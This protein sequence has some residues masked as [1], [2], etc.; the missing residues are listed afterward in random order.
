[1]AIHRF[2]GFTQKCCLS[3][4]NHF[5][6]NIFV[7]LFDIKRLNILYVLEAARDICVYVWTG[8]LCS[9]ARDVTKHGSR[10]PSPTGV[11]WVSD[12]IGINFHRIYAS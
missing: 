5:Y 11:N 1:M 9:S 4:H 10:S 12:R 7:F 3:L 8:R 2:N 6:C